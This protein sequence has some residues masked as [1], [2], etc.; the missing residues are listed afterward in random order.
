MMNIS[1]FSRT[2]T[3]DILKNKRLDIGD[4]DYTKNVLLREN[5]F[6][7]NGYRHLFM[8]PSN[9]KLFLEGTRFEELYALFFFFITILFR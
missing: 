3:I 4:V 8:D 9:T 7:L 6:F 2:H 1:R 5:Y